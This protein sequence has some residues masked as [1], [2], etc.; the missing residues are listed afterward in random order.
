M[1]DLGAEE[2]CGFRQL[3]QLHAFHTGMTPW[4][5]ARVL[6][7]L[8]RTLRVLVRGDFLCEALEALKQ[9]CEEE[10]TEPPELPLEEFWSSEQYFFHDQEQLKM[11]NEVGAG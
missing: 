2:I 4:G 5:Q 6:R 10:G 3:A 7:R 8:R 9:D 11:V 1:T